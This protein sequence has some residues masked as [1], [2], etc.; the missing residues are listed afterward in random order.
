[1][2]RGHLIYMKPVF[3]KPGLSTVPEKITKLLLVL[4]PRNCWN[5]HIY[6]VYRQQ[7]QGLLVPRKFRKANVYTQ[8]L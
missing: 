6:Y 8:K 7:Q 5:N 4:G 3:T 1:M 2:C